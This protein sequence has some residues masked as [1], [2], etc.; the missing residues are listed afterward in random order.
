MRSIIIVAMTIGFLT[1][2]NDILSHIITFGSRNALGVTCRRIAALVRKETRIVYFHAYLTDAAVL[3]F[4]NRFPLRLRTVTFDAWKRSRIIAVL[5]HPEL[6]RIEEI[7]LF[8]FS[9]LERGA[10][11]ETDLSKLTALKRLKLQGSTITGRF[12]PKALQ[13]LTLHH[14]C[15]VFDKLHLPPTVQHLCIDTC[16]NL[17]EISSLA[18]VKL[19]RKKNCPAP[20]HD[21]RGRRYTA[22][23]FLNEEK[24]R[25]I[26]ALGGD[27]NITDSS[28]ET[29]LHLLCRFGGSTSLVA[30]LLANGALLNQHDYRIREPVDIAIENGHDEL[31]IYLLERGAHSLYLY[32][33]TL[34]TAVR[35]GNMRLAELLIKLCR[36]GDIEIGLALHVAVGKKF[37]AMADLLLRNGADPSSYD[38]VKKRTPLMIARS[39]KDQRMEALI[40]SYL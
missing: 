26:L 32:E 36:E 23:S 10:N 15:V 1:L 2:P 40:S 33:R 6:N 21:F 35:R 11:L 5:D 14:C 7:R 24:A 19:L 39:K 13:S 4:L 25:T 30:L 8:D 34:S 22:S 9:E 28:G 20:A 12:L 38:Y 31:A 18:N 27:P 3:N 16:Q 37:L 29:Y 17:A